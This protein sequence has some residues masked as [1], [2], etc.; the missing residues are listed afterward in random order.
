MGTKMADSHFTDRI[1]FVEMQRR[2]MLSAILR[3]VSLNI[4]LSPHQHSK[5]SIYI[6]YDHIYKHLIKC[7]FVSVHHGCVLFS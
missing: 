5:L 6:M 3:E 2:K 4:A 1:N 7:T